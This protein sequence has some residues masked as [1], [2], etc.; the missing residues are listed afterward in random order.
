MSSKCKPVVGSSKNIIL[1]LLIFFKLLKLPKVIQPLLFAG[2]LSK[3]TFNFGVLDY[4]LA[5]GGSIMSV[6]EDRT[7]S[8]YSFKTFNNL[9]VSLDSLLNE[10]LIEIKVYN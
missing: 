3:T 4:S 2:I 1:G 6:P 8:T 7:I 5:D 9:G 10:T